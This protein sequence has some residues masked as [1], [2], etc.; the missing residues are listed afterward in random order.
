MKIRGRLIVAFLIM[1]VFPLCAGA[2]SFHATLQNQTDT[3]IEYYGVDPKDYKNY[4]IL[5]NPIK[6][7]YNIT[8]K[9]FTTI[10]NVADS[11]PDKLLNYNV[12]DTISSAFVKKDSFIVVKKDGR[13]YYI[14]DET[15]YKNIPA[16]PPFS[17][18]KIGN[19]NNITLNADNSFLIREKDFYYADNSEGQVFL[20]TNLSKLLPYWRNSLRDLMLCFLLIIVITGT[21]LIVWL[22]HSIVKPLNILHIATM[23][24]GAGNLDN[25]V[26]VTTSDEIGELCRDFEEMR[27]RL[28]SILEERIQYEQDTRDM[29]S[30]IS[31]D[32]KTPLTAIKG[33]AEGLIDGVAKTPDKQEQYLKTIINKAVD[34]TY[35]VDEL[36]LFAKIEQNALPY[37]FTTIDIG[38]YFDDCIEDM[39]FDLEAHKIKI[40]Y[41]NH[42]APGTLIT[43]DPEQLKRVINNISGNSVKYMDKKDGILKISIQDVV[44]LPVSPPLYR[45]INEDG[46]DVMPPKVQEEFIRVEI[47]DNGPGI[48]KRDLPFIFDR[49]YRAD[50]SRNSSKGGSGLGLAIVQK[51]ISDHGGKIWAASTLGNGLSIYFTLKK[52]GVE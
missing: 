50:A 15:C 26:R 20:I 32:L 46:T 16:L 8:L 34:M 7:L 51:I 39:V 45:Q 47:S 21:M 33:Y 6:V 3:I 48:D 27:I 44:P 36:S 14:G 25:P 24:I 35:L 5:L 29:M 10:T 1:T 38:E 49:F 2:A 4:R 37:N 9:D 52:K 19:N 11:A 18:H 42:T 12:L 28:K 13:D 30:S 40:V 22:Y 43:A 17:R 41:E 23:Q 31:H